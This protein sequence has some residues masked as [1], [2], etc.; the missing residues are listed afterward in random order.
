M[1]ASEGTAAIGVS[2]AAGAAVA[3]LAPV[4]G[5]FMLLAIFGKGVIAKWSRTSHRSPPIAQQK[6]RRSKEGR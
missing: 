4:A 5:A 6:A 2:S 1:T 3:K